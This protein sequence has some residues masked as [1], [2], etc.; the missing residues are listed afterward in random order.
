MLSK[1]ATICGENLSFWL[2]LVCY[3]FQDARIDYAEFTAMM[4]KGDDEIGRM[5][6]IR[7]SLSLNL[8][9]ALGV[10]ESVMEPDASTN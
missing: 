7:S 1:R 10:N 5:K 6:T 3:V 2:I 8:A 4:R 9:D